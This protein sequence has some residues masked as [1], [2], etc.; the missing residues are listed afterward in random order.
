[1]DLGTE[2]TRILSGGVS[3]DGHH[4]AL[5]VAGHEVLLKTGPDGGKTLQPLVTDAAR[6]RLARPIGVVAGARKGAWAIELDEV[7]TKPKAM[8]W[9]DLDGQAHF[10]AAASPFDDWGQAEL[11][12]VGATVIAWDGK[13]ALVTLDT[14]AA[15]PTWKPV[16]SP[17]GAAVTGVSR[18]LPRK[19]FLLTSA[20]TVFA[21]PA[22]DL[23]AA[24][25]LATPALVGPFAVALAGCGALADGT[26]VARVSLSDAREGQPALDTACRGVIFTP[27]AGVMS[28]VGR[29]FF[30]APH[31]H[32]RAR[33][34]PCRCRAA[35]RARQ[36]CR[37]PRGSES[38][39]S[40][41][42]PAS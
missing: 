3:P 21:A 15:V 41:G 27:K 31:R 11:W 28:P 26:L 17:G 35:G 38:G 5:I 29:L 9:I 20:T 10:E 18:H 22:V 25:T 1:L 13:R 36:R 39:A 8:V 16:V 30:T 12:A 4:E 2:G 42:A 6:Q 14:A 7:D 34:A 37:R 40:R 33:A 32:P 23:G 19:R 24:S